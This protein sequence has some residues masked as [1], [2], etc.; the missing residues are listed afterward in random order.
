MGNIIYHKNLKGLISPYEKN[1]CR[2]HGVQGLL[3][4]FSQSAEQ[5]YISVDYILEQLK[6]VLTNITTVK[7]RYLGKIIEFRL[8]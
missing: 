6:V 3:K 4:K 2:V 7:I 5:V 1:C 8:R